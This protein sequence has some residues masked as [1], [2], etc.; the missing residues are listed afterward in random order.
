MPTIEPEPHEKREVAESFGAEAERYNRARPSYPQE[1]IH[2]IA[3]NSPGR[4]TLDVG[5]GT[6]IVSR[7]FQDENQD[8]L[9][10]D[11]DEKM[12]EQARHHGLAVEVA[13][14]EEWDPRGRR[15]DTVVAAQA[16]HWI[17]PVAG[18]AKAAEILTPTGRIALIWNVMEPE[19]TARQAMAE[20]IESTMSG[21]PN[22][23]AGERP[24]LETYGHMFTKA[25]DG[26]DK[27]G[28]FTRPERWREDWQ[29][30][31][32]RTE[33]LDQLP[34]FGGMSRLPKN[35]L[36]DLLHRTAAA[37]ADSFVMRYTT[38]AVTATR[39]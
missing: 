6:G 28:N 26:L 2:R 1:L 22:L 23:W 7:Q 34:T 15:F 20:A 5:C 17:D 14:F 21:F 29:R 30:T 8:V 13:K 37:I 33:W 12:A 4:R 19:P 9:G 10:L 24:I 27:S 18:A 39:S 16:W 32:T 31:Y 11:A 36:D 25:E 38:V 35:T 3:E